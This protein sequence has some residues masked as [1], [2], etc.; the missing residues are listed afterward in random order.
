MVIAFD[1]RHDEALEILSRAVAL[2]PKDPD[3][4][5]GH[6]KVTSWKG[7]FEDAENSVEAVLADY[8]DYV[9][10]WNLKGRIAFY[11][12]N[13]SEA[14]RAFA[15]ARKLAPDNLEPLLGAG[16][17]AF[18]SGEREQAEML[19]RAALA[20]APNSLEAQKRIDQLTAEPTIEKPW[21]IDITGTESRFSRQSRKKWRSGSFWI[22][23]RLDPATTVFGAFEAE[24][25]FAHT[26][27]G[28]IAG[29]SHRFTPWLDAYAEVGTAIAAQFRPRWNIA[30]GG[31]LRVL[32]N[33]DIFG[34]SIFTVDARHR[35]YANSSVT[36]L[37]PGL[38]QYLFDGRVWITGRWLNSFDAS[39]K[40]LTG[41]SARVDAQVLER[42]RLKVGWSDAPESDAGVSVGTQSLT[43]GIVVGVTPDVDLRLDFLREDRENSYIKKDVSTGLTIRF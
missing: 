42:L 24:N 29:V 5:L 10:A 12:E 3:I 37:T 8:P 17:V 19:F 2:S 4:R 1:G 9:D 36:D 41:W 35:E 26:D 6:A 7:R 43:A 28:Y 16:D 27:R 22:S 13:F 30:V 21:R 34:P 20:L 25:R 38:R 11:Q 23:R 32:E 33:G 14:A 39:A 31:G 40:R 18:A 15:R